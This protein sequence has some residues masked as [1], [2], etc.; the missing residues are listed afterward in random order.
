MKSEFQTFK[1]ALALASLNDTCETNAL[2]FRINTLEFNDF[3]YPFE[4]IKRFMCVCTSHLSRRS[5]AFEWILF[6]NDNDHLRPN[7]TN[8]TLYSYRVCV[9]V[10]AHVICSCRAIR[11]L[12]PTS[13]VH[14]PVIPLGGR[15]TFA[16]VETYVLYAL[17]TILKS[18]YKGLWF[19]FKQLYRANAESCLG[20]FVSECDAWIDYG[21]TWGQVQ[22]W[23][24]GPVSVMLSLSRFSNLF[25]LFC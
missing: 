11:P 5:Y 1:S 19:F 21:A 7:K 2:S 24:T 8:K 15:M 4:Y 6:Y 17:W 9:N 3:A 12:E 13:Q 16:W 18:T 22:M 23:R 10:C 25:W 20:G 14:R